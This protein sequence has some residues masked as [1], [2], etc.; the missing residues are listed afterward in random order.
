MEQTKIIKRDTSNGLLPQVWGPH[1]WKS[2]HFIAFS[3]PINPTKEDKE[4]YKK[5]FE[6]LQYVLP[7]SACATSYGKFITDPLSPVKLTDT[8]FEN[9]ASITH[10]IYDLHNIVNKKLHVEYNYTYED[11]V[12]EMESFR[13]ICT[14]VDHHGRC[15]M[16]QEFK[17]VAYKNEY[18]KNFRVLSYDIAKY[19]ENYAKSRGILFDKLNDCNINCKIYNND[20]WRERNDICN[21]I[22]EKM[23]LNGISPYDENGLP[24][25]DEL[26]LISYMTHSGTHDEVIRAAR[27]LGYEGEYKYIIVNLNK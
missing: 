2:L 13:F 17:N 10:W 21:K 11:F 23:R 9:R 26:L 15:I 25:D 5:Y 18:R 4:H 22:I 24:T 1:M 27:K 12:T 7:C 14:D 20:F 19:F 3:Y 6:V 16:P 8:I